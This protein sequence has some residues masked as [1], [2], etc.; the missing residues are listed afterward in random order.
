MG[1]QTV[2]PAFNPNQPYQ[3]I[4]S[5][6]PFDPSKPFSPAG[7][8]SQKYSPNESALQG[9]GN[10]MTLGNLPEM[11]GAAESA[12]EK[13]LGFF[14]V[15]PASTDEALRK[16]GFKMA[17]PATMGSRINEAAKNQDQ[18]KSENP[19]AYTGGAV[20]GTIASI[21]T[22]G[23]AGRG[24]VGA[25]GV[26]V[27]DM[28]TAGKIATSAGTGGL[29]AA[30]TAPEKQ[31][32]MS[33]SENI[34][35]RAKQGAL[36]ALFGGTISGAGAAVSGLIGPTAS[37]VANEYAVKSTG[38]M[39][40]DMR[41]IYGTGQMGQIA[42]EMFNSGMAEAGNNV[43]TISKKSSELLK[44]VG[45][46][47]GSIYEEAK[48]YA[49]TKDSKALAQD[50][51]NIVNQNSPRFHADKYLTGITPY[52]EGIFKHPEELQDIRSV[53]GI[54]GDIDAKI[55]YYSDLKG[56]QAAANLPEADDIQKGLYAI[57]K[58]LRG[59]VNQSVED[60]GKISG[61]E[62]LGQ[63]LK[64][65]NQRYGSLSTINKVSTDRMVRGT[66]NSSMG[67]LPSLAGS[68]ALGGVVSHLGAGDVNSAAKAVAAGLGTAVAAKAL[69]KY[70]APAA[71]QAARKISQSGLI[72]PVGAGVVG[73]LIGGNQ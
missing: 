44:S 49:P 7:E 20:A 24:L 21:P 3:S 39:L 43:A 50:I 31:E 61:N 46:R 9:F 62:H 55:N 5:K 34:S 45:Q 29:M 26:P 58:H 48:G 17:P 36:G 32:K 4:D 12:T 65:L 14:G 63:E 25:A 52:V 22:Y 40:K 67:L 47:I 19:N 66:T 54:I 23:M 38:A 27:A 18:M 70:G 15:G 53:N 11:Q 33:A 60:F 72:P 73:G 35:E 30:A 13:G 56:S 28:G 57:R 1:S 8:E 68:A 51:E 64:N 10:A 42:D 69:Q 37:K 41:K 71:A 59:V 16:S 6:P 2:K